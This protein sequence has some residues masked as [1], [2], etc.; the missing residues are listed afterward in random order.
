MDEVGADEELRATIRDGSDGVCV[1]DFLE[2][3]FS[4]GK[5]ATVVRGGAGSWQCSSHL[6][7]PHVHSGKKILP[8]EAVTVTR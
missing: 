6:S 2:E 1:P 3:A 4:H 7:K 5:C 8:G